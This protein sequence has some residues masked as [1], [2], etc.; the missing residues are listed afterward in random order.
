MFF[1]HLYPKRI[2]RDSWPEVFHRPNGLP[3]TQSAVS[4]HRYVASVL[5]WLPI[6]HIS[7]QLFRT[8]EED[9]RDYDVTATTVETDAVSL[10]DSSGVMLLTEHWFRSGCS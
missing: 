2:T 3:D 9:I 8:R 5:H 1:L 6:S 4:K 7:G 10:S